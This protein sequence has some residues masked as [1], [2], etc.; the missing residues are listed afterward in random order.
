MK[1]NYTSRQLW[2][3]WIDSGGREVHYNA[4]VVPLSWWWTLWF[5]LCERKWIRQTRNFIPVFPGQPGYEDALYA[6]TTLYDPKEM[7][8]LID[9]H[10]DAPSE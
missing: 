2:E 5:L 4:E 1:N 9:L 6:S 7:K 3:D 8:R 10:G